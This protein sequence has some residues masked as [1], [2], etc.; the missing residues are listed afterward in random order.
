MTPF[1]LK[2]VTPDKTL[3]DGEAEHRH[4][5]PIAALLKLHFFFA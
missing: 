3:F 4:T 5:N 2:I 1:K